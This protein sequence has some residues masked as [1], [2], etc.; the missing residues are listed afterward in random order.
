MKYMGSKQKHAKEIFSA[1]TSEVGGSILGSK[2][3]V[4]VEPFVGGSNMMS[5]VPKMLFSRR[6]GIDNNIHLI[7]MWKA[8]I[9]GWVAP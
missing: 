4:W 5:N 9:T 1:I 6:I 8:L 3:E 7:E 2:Y